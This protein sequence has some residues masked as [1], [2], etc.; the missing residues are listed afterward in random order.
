MCMIFQQDP[1]IYFA[2]WAAAAAVQDPDNKSA[3][4]VRQ[5]FSNLVTLAA[6]STV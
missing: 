3:D 5:G 2:R 6:L 1:G 4:D